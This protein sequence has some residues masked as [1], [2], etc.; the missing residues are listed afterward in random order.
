MDDTRTRYAHIIL[1]YPSFHFTMQGK[2]KVLWEC[3]IANLIE[4][5]CC[6]T[7][8]KGKPHKPIQ[9]AEKMVRKTDQST[10]YRMDKKTSFVTG[11]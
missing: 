9:F 8:L 5:K 4:L 10:L 7:G 11:K 6:Y 1:I 3:K 2:G